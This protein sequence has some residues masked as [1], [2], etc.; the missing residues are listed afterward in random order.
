MHG[1]QGNTFAEWRQIFVGVE[2][3]EFREIE[4][5]FLD[6]RFRRRLRHTPQKAHRLLI[7]VS[8]AIE[9]RLFERISQDL[10]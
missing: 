10:G 6:R 4:E 5:S 1:E 2:G 3:T 7:T 8:L 9:D